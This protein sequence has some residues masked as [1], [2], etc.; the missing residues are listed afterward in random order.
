MGNLIRSGRWMALI[1][2][3]AG[4]GHERAGLEA[5]KRG[6]FAAAYQEYRQEESPEAH[7]AIGIMHYKGDGVLRNHATAL[8]HFQ[9]A[10][11]GGHAGAQYNLGLMYGSG[12][13]GVAKDMREAARWYRLAAEQGYARAQYNL[14]LMYARGDG[15]PQN[16]RE[17]LRWLVKAAKQGH[18]KAR[19]Q[20]A[21]MMEEREIKKR[22][23]E[24]H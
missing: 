12:S 23:L 18:R 5:Y 9:L 4:C 11:Q 1:L 10:A 19:E 22:V 24:N 7:F 14:G 13:D 3:L 20:L 16:R 2:V 21:D 6:D 17:S 8:Q 15:V